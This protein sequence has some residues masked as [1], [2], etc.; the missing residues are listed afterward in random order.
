MPLPKTKSV[1]KIMRFLKKEKPSWS[2]EKKIAVALEQARKHGANI[3][4]NPNMDDVIKHGKK[5]KK[6]RK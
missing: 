6:R 3:N 2:R 1:A 4:P 5:K